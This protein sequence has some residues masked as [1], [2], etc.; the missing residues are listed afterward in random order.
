MGMGCEMLDVYSILIILSRNSGRCSFYIIIRDSS[1]FR[2]EI[3]GVWMSRGYLRSR[4]LLYFATTNK[5][6]QEQK[7]VRPFGTRIKYYD[8]KSTEVSREFKNKRGRSDLVAAFRNANAKLTR[9]AHLLFA[10][11]VTVAHGPPCGHRRRW[12]AFAT[13]RRKRALARFVV[14]RETHGP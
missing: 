11:L 3:L 13:W 8:L 12:G 5:F 14:A 9:T 6:Q 2:A 4:P 7:Q 1:G 10:A